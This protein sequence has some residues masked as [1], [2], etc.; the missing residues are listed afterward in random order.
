MEGD[1]LMKK[2]PLFLSGYFVAI[3]GL[4]FYSYTQVD[5]SLTFSRASIFQTIEKG[6]QYIGYFN[7][8]LSTDIYTGL[9]TLLFLFYFGF[10]Y[11]AKVKQISRST[12]WLVIFATTAILLLTYNAFSYDFF[13][14]IF[15][16]KIITHYHQNPYLVKALDFPREPML[17]FMH[18]TH[19]TY[20]YGPIWLVL[21]V[22]L[23]FLGMQYFLPTF[24]LYKLLAGACFIG[25]VY[26]L[27]K[28]LKRIAPDS[29]VQGLILFA[30]NPLVYI[31]MLVSAHNDGAMIFF[32]IFGVYLLLQ[33]KWV[34]G[35]ISILLSIF[36]KE[37]TAFLILPALLYAVQI[38][39]KK[40][41]VSE[42]MFL[43]GCAL[44]MIGGFLFAISKIEVQ[45]WYFVWFFP[46]IIVFKI[47]R[48]IF[49]VVIG[50]SFGLMLRYVPFLYQG[51]WNGLALVVKN[52]VTIVTPIIFGFVYGIW[53][54]F[55]QS[56]GKA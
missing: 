28:I 20:P 40:Q 29:V 15:Y 22:P 46:F 44:S 24:F 16:G 42:N 30:L 21:T 27:E 51:D 13:N 43:W 1:I 25:T 55:T 14:Y 53:Y 56:H 35:L 33:K 41:F 37:A 17:S 6:F 47:P 8:P 18:W 36:T 26:F 7:R 39:F 38:I 11:L 19:N 32:A 23:S 10:L 48:S 54:Y 5:L 12:V 45:P 4:F 49:A 2:I 50:F 9:L 52:Y 3:I 34:F 31:E